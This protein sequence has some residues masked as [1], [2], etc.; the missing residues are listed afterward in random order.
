MRI[1]IDL[2]YT[3]YNVEALRREMIRVAREHANVTGEQFRSAEQQ[4]KQQVGF[5]EPMRHAS[6]LVEDVVVRQRIVDAWM[7]IVDGGRL[8]LYS[9]AIDFLQRHHDEDTVL[10]S[11]G[12]EG[13]Q[14]RKIEGAGVADL[15]DHVVI[16]STSKGDIFPTL[17]DH[18]PLFMVNDRG[19][20]L[21]ALK[22]LHPGAVA[23]WLRRPNNPYADEPC[24][25]VDRVI[26]DLDI[27]LSLVQHN[28]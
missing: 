24:R 10:L 14:R 17:I 2:D 11:F 12:H 18:D 27:D 9:D 5:Y 1:I 8:F 19:S 3:L 20:E 23:V 21:D 26:T 15:V 28:S 7:A 25:L 6:L 4:V 22:Q 16:T 13:W